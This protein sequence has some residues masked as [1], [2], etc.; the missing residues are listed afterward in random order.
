M[1]NNQPITQRERT[2]P[3]QQRLISTTDAHGVITYCNDAFVEISG[4]SREELLKAP[5]NTVRHPDV[6][7]AVFEHMWT[8]LKQGLPWM[9]IVKNRSKNGDHYW[10]NA[11]VTPIFDNQRVVGYESVRVKPSAEQVQ[12]AEALYQRLNKGK[13]AVPG[14]DKWLPVLQDWLPFIL[15]SQLGFLIGAWLDSPWGFALAAGLSVPLG[16]LGLT[17][18]QRGIKRLLRLAGQTTSDPLIAQMY[19]DS[20]GPQARL[21]MS[22][23]SQE[24]RMK[25]CLTRL[26]DTAEQLNGQAQQAD[27]LAHAS[28]AGLERQRVET[29]QVATAI[30]QMAATT[31]EVASHV[32]RT[33]D[34]TQ[35]ANQLTRRGRDIAGETRDA[36]QRLSRAVGETGLT[37][38]QLAQ[39]SNE[40]GGV[41]DVIKG[42]ADQTNLL[43][44]NAA[45][46]AARAGEMG[47]GFAVVADEVRQLAQRT[48]ES[49]GQIHG[50][51]AK[52]Q[53]TANAAVQTMNAGHRQAEEGVARVLEADQALVGISEAVANITDMTTQ[54]AAATEEQSS[55]AEEISRNIATIAHLADQTSEEAQ[56][57]AALSEELTGTAN[58]QYSL[59]ERFNR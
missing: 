28:S 59:V 26:Q 44:L 33:A 23:L 56:R 55:V 49:T 37:V 38:T 43:A 53:G 41:V 45:I 19:T 40:I 54:I 57:S 24:A 48:T 7:S 15:V 51:I 42:I 14:R 11:Y 30:N 10:V 5:H 22:I 17:W 4:F 34:A 1:R 12:R 25:T 20:R 46:E 35:Q 13:S 9:G 52:L 16:L 39:D 31:Q 3:A 58:A 32:Q 2:F 36:I 18:Q 8:T 29:E 47:R 27:S 6:P 50:L 21:E